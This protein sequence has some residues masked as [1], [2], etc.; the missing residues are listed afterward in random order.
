M[1]M[2]VIGTFEWE[3]FNVI[4]K[5]PKSDALVILV[6]TIVTVLTDLATA[7]FIG[8]IIS[9]LVFAWESAKK[10]SIETKKRDD[11]AREYLLKVQFSL[12]QQHILKDYLIQQFLK[13]KFI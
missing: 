7:V 3:T 8:I 10:I 13:M 6:V 5:I 12:V 2:V 9:A 4:K 11:G 1:F